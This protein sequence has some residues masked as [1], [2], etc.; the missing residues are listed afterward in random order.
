MRVF[1][2]L[3][4]PDPVTEALD[5]L[6]TDLRAGRHVAAENMHLTL[7][8]LGELALPD[9]TELDLNLQQINV[10]PVDL[11]LAGLE[12]FGGTRPRALVIRAEGGAPLRHMR[13]KV[14]TAARGVG[15]DMPRERFRPH[16]TL[17]R[18][19]QTMPEE[20]AARL[21]RFMAAH[22]DVALPPTTVAGF[23]LYRSYL[24]TEGAEYEV[25][26]DYPATA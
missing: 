2:G 13:D 14:R 6:Q 17:A 25:L 11:R 15:L 9:L 10:E 18:F 23:A 26:A 8:F 16:V 12:L 7:A 19:R 5:A 21:G 3:P 4:L 20:E 1:I 22:G 24:S